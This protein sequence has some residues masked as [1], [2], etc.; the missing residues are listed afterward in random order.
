MDLDAFRNVYNRQREHSLLPSLL[1]D[2]MCV[3]RTEQ[4]RGILPFLQMCS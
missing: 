1:G 3:E 4:P 2:V